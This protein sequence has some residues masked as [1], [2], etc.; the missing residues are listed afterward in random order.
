MGKGLVLLYTG[1]GKGKTTAAFG[2]VLRALGHNQKVAIVQFF[3]GKAQ[4]T[5]VFK[6]INK[7]IKI[8]NYGKKFLCQ[9]SAK[10]NCEL[11]RRAWSRCLKVLNDPSYFLLV[12]DE[13]H[14]ALHYRFLETAEV[15]KAL[16]KRP[17]R[18]HVLLTGRGAPPV[19]MRFA[20]IVTVMKCVKHPF[21]RGLS[22]QPGIEF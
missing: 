2:A 6:K 21:E 12:I 11:V 1:E 8:W 9:N 15:I 22:A 19:L 18:Q 4:E 13:I 17:P 14:I 3:K 7:K 16:K 10:T 5:K 20:D